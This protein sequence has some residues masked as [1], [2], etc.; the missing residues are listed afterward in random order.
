MAR[1]AGDSP[2]YTFYLNGD[3]DSYSINMPSVTTII[4]S[5]LAA[6][7][8]VGWAYKLGKEGKQSM[9]EVLDQRSAEGNAAHS[10]L[11]NL[12]ADTPDLVATDAYQEGIKKWW[13]SAGVALQGISSE[14][15]VLSTQHFYAGTLDLAASKIGHGLGI[16]DL[17]T[18]RAPARKSWRKAYESDLI[19]VA[20]YRLAYE[21]MY[22]EKPVWSGV[23]LAYD[24]GS[25][26]FDDREAST[27]LF[28]DILSVYNRL[29]EENL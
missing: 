29:R 3:K 13:D 8:L 7:A 14:Q 12:V 25:Y 23:L 11:E 20:A 28:L 10:Y 15:V 4:K 19:Q 6:P 5:V 9:K 17:K 18:R 2:H 24:D 16:I 27:D 21:E 1:L 22:G 26:E